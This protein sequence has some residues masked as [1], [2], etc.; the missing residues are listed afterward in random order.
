MIPVSSFKPATP[1]FHAKA[2]AVTFQGNASAS[3][4][5]AKTEPA[6]LTATR[7]GIPLVYPGESSLGYQWAANDYRRLHAALADDGPLMPN[8]ESAKKYL[9]IALREPQQELERLNRKV[10]KHPGFEYDYASERADTRTKERLSEEI[11]KINA[12]LHGGKQATVPEDLKD[13]SPV[14]VGRV[15]QM[16]KQIADEAESERWSHNI[17]AMPDRATARSMD[18]P[19]YGGLNEETLQALRASMADKRAFLD[20]KPGES[21]LLIRRRGRVEEDLFQAERK[22]TELYQKFQAED[23]PQPQFSILT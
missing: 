21:L 17:G 18:L 16:R 8:E 4:A 10:Y 13:L 3:D 2:K 15:L 12:Y 1:S 11:S 23:N 9:Q 6:G 5:S 20:S 22:L 7:N 19:F 14:R